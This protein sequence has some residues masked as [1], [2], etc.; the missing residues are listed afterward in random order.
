MLLM[1]GKDGI[2]GQGLQSPNRRLLSVSTLNGTSQSLK[3]R[4]E[5]DPHLSATTVVNTGLDQDKRRL[6]VTW[7][8]GD[9][10][11]YPYV[12]LRDCCQCSACFHSPTFSRRLHF[13]ELDVNLMPINVETSSATQ[14]IVITWSDEHRSVFRYAWLLKRSFRF[15]EQAIRARWNGRHAV[16]WGSHLVDSIPQI[17]FEQLL[18]SDEAM[19]EWLTAL[20]ETGFAMLTGAPHASGQLHHIADKV[21]FLRRTDLGET[22]FE[23]HHKENS[24]DLSYTL[25]SQELHNDLT[26]YHVVPGMK[27]VHCISQPSSGEVQSVQ[28]VDGFKAAKQLKDRSPE[29]FRLLTTTKLDFFS[30]GS[31]SRMLSRHPTIK[32]DE[33]GDIVQINYSTRHRD[34]YSRQP[35]EEVEPLYR[36]LKSFAS[37]LYD[38]QNL[39]EIKLQNDVIYC[40]NN[41]RVLHGRK[42]FQMVAGSEPRL[43]RGYIDW[44]D[45]HSK[46]RLLKSKL[47]IADEDY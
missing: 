11:S 18:V 27:M 46:R 45:L 19:Y 20:E 15:A 36:A 8:D 25:S 28:F 44:D 35:P 24:T 38:Q 39:V 22:S 1:Q 34:T 14:E 4:V 16:L 12:W 21:S 17:S 7:N 10:T 40:F 32:L 6:D 43:E 33:A 3:P 30:A 13:H 26:Y 42:A 9:Q 23:H 31:D 2:M 5:V 47:R 29:Q 37:L 41:W